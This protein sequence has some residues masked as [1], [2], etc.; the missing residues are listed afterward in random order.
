[1]PIRS[2]G[3]RR[4]LTD[5]RVTKLCSCGSS[6]GEATVSYGS[7][8]ALGLWSVTKLKGPEAS[9][10]RAG[11]HLSGCSSTKQHKTIVK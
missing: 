9:T 3:I 7:E 1:M 2:L 6:S 11:G 8:S 4:Y 10:G 5:V